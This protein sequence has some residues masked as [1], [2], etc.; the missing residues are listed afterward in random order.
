[1]ALS[2]VRISWLMFARNADFARF[3][4]CFRRCRSRLRPAAPVG[5]REFGVR[6]RTRLPDR[7][8][9]A[10]RRST[11]CVRQSPP[12]D[13][14]SLPD[15]C[16]VAKRRRPWLQSTPT[17]DG[18]GDSGGERCPGLPQKRDPPN[19]TAR[20]RSVQGRPATS[21]VVSHAACRPARR[22]RA[23]RSPVPHRY[24]RPRR[25]APSR[26]PLAATR[27]PDRRSGRRRR[28]TPSGG[29]ALLQRSTRR[30]PV[31]GQQD[32]KSE[33]RAG[34]LHQPDRRRRGR[35]AGIA[36]PLE[37]RPALVL[38]PQIEPERRLVP[39]RCSMK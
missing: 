8:A 31:D 15:R 9:D 28:R 2:G 4:P 27:P 20:K 39:P 17:E 1:M 3:G 18:D 21:I 33:L 13:R 26:R 19:A 6:S 34:L 16:S 35:Q 25:R 10:A 36:R 11:R 38:R 29:P 14:P 24:R 12:R 22:R 30:S 23:G 32:E 37:R 7:R 5:R